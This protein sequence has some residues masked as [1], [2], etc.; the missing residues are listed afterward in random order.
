MQS[1]NNFGDVKVVI[2]AG[3]EGVRLCPLTLTR[4]KPM[5]WLGK[6]TVIQHLMRLL[7][8]AGFVNIIIT[9]NYLKEQVMHFLG[10]GSRYGVRIEYVV[11]P[12]GIFLGTAGGLKLASHKL[13]DNFIVMQGDSFTNIDIGEALR[14]HRRLKS[15]ATVVLKE[16]EDPWNYGVV[17]CDLEGRI[18]GF[19]EKPCKG[20]E[21]SKLISTGIY[22]LEPEI[23]DYISSGES[24]FAKNIFPRL[25]NDGERILGFVG[26]GFWSDIGSL[27]GYLE[28]T[29]QVLECPAHQEN[30]YEQVGVLSGKNVT[31]NEP[32]TLMSPVLLEKGAAIGRGSRIGPIAVVKTNS[33]IGENC[34][35]E[36]AA[37]FEDVAI[38]HSCTIR[39]S[40][41]GEHA[42][43]A[44]NIVV[45]DSVVGPGSFL[46]E[47]VRLGKGSRIWPSIVVGPKVTVDGALTLPTDKPFYFYSDFGEYTGIIASNISD[48]A[49]KLE[50]VELKSIELH[51][52][53]RD[54]ERWIRDVFQA[55]NLAAKLSELR[56]LGIRG[57]ESRQQL[58][59]VIRDWLEYSTDKDLSRTRQGIQEKADLNQGTGEPQISDHEEVTLSKA[60]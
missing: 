46:N 1:S 29:R 7:S 27:K 22:C 15:D 45:E 37:I 34:K 50:T 5:M 59:K 28:G 6:D 57:E 23:L 47:G 4:P 20:E 31:I 30:S 24:D 52:Y 48:M 44:D 35:I 42:V 26:H 33:K 60:W 10:D 39:N 14:F 25:L 12:E 49:G 11:E 53:H 56:K 13:S 2:L 43:L 9:V 58:I 18:T 17:E 38:G 16:V 3:G 32:V 21:R 19:Q 51:L 54:F 55:N 36:N 40:V 41:I 8:E